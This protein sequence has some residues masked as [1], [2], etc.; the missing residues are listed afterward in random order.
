MY[1]LQSSMYG[2]NVT[3]NAWYVSPCYMY[4]CMYVCGMYGNVLLCMYV[5]CGICMYV[6]MCIYVYTYV[7]I[8]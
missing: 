6:C 5:V 2:V 8:T 3:N 4:V 7:I 1:V